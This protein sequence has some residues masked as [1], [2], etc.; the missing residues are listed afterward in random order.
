M[1]HVRLNYGYFTHFGLRVIRNPASIH[2]GD[3]AIGT[4]GMMPNTLKELREADPNKAARK[5]ATA[6]LERIK[7]IVGGP[8]PYMAA[9]ILWERGP[10]ARVDV[11]AW[12]RPEALKRLKRARQEWRPIQRAKGADGKTFQ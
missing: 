7:G 3:A 10:R 12:R 6:I 11:G 2:D 1:S 4:Y 9:V 5:L 8:C